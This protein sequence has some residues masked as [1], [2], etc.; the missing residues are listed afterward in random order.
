MDGRA[1]AR[2]TAGTGVAHALRM[3]RRF[4][5]VAAT[6]LVAGCT[7]DGDGSGGGFRVEIDGPVSP[8]YT[9]GVLTF[10]IDVHGGRPDSVELRR[11]G[12]LLTTLAYPYLWA[13]DTSSIDEG[14]YGIVAVAVMGED[15]AESAPVSVT[16]DRTA[17]AFVDRSPAAG[18]EDVDV[19]GNVVIVL[20]E[21]I[22]ERT[23]D[24]AQ[25]VFAAGSPVMGADLSTDGKTLTM[26][27][28]ASFN[29]TPNIATVD[30]S[31]VRDLAGNP[32]DAGNWSYELP[33][34]L[35]LG[36]ADRVPS[37]DATEPAI[38]VDANGRPVVAF[39]EDGDLFVS[40]WNGTAWIALGG[41][42][43]VVA[44]NEIATP[45]I[46]VDAANDPVVA[47][48][49]WDAGPPVTQRLLHA[50][51]WNGSSWVSM[52]IA[53]NETAEDAGEPV[54]IID[55]AG[56]PMI[57]WNEDGRV[58]TARRPD[59]AWQPG[60]AGLPSSSSAT[61]G[62]LTAAG[63]TT[64]L[65]LRDGAG[66]VRAYSWNGNWNAI[67]DAV[68]VSG[69]TDVSI[70]WD[71]NYYQPVVALAEEIS[72]GVFGL[73]VRQFDGASSWY[74]LTFTPP[75]SS[76]AA[77]NPRL[78]DA[79]IGNGGFFPE[80]DGAVPPEPMY[81]SLQIAW[82]EN[83][84]VRA[85]VFDFFEWSSMGVADHDPSADAGRPSV[86]HDGGHNLF[87]AWHEDDESAR[88]VRVGRMNRR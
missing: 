8:A 34:W 31:Q 49:E 58:R 73:R 35:S 87:L 82:N 40:R 30:L 86:A 1:L 74:D 75:S 65:V 12:V 56:D 6:V 46:A 22:D 41:A 27:A 4:A 51:Q 32:V 7:G 85:A 44:A 57:A 84:D 36:A 52:G 45:V 38:A 61:G 23:V 15:V 3:V 83:G 39:L 9:N 5:A 21:A 47:W 55:A 54:L 66:A 78:T 18:A 14:E 16:V 37:A 24:Q 80:G 72:P 64:R 77:S 60:G 53:L 17:P 43:D 69:R 13:W 68:A 71:G 26:A 50:A 59:S 29:P 42:L 76:P 88:S 63:G 67:G 28:F 20:D 2:V 10:Q 11:D 19:Y 79:T 70:T 48:I 33:A 62:F 25:V 81:P